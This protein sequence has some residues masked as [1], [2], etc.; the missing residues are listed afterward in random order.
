MERALNQLRNWWKLTLR[1]P[2]DVV[3]GTIVEELGLFPYLAAGDAGS[4]NAGALAYVLNAV[5]RA[6]VDGDTSL[7]AALDALDEALRTDEVE[8]PLQPGR[9]DVVRIMNL[10]KAKGLEAK[11]VIL[12]HPAGLPGGTVNSVVRRPDDRR[13]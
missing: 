1:L 11:I 6:G 12:A 8:A 2:A 5:R 13:P 9:D 3:I 10:H 7:R 4:S